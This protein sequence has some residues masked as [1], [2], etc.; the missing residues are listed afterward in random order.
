MNNMPEN[1]IP[2]VPQ[3]DDAV[4]GKEAG[5]QMLAA[6]CA[7]RDA[8]YATLGTV[9][10]D[11]LAWRKEQAVKAVWPMRESLLVCLRPGV[12]A[13]RLVRSAA[14][15]AGQLQVP[16]HA[17]YVE[18]PRLQRLPEAER[19]RILK[20]LHLAH[21]LGAQITNRAADDSADTIV[22]YA[23][24][25][26]LG[27]V[28]LG[29]EQPRAWWWQRL[30][31]GLAQRLLA[32]APDLDI[33]Q[34]A[35]AGVDGERPA[36]ERNTERTTALGANASNAADAANPHHSLQPVQAV[37]F[38]PGCLFETVRFVENMVLPVPNFGF[39]H[40]NMAH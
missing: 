7:A 2:H 12:G 21:T 32:R 31:P 3:P 13:E 15:L 24:E 4:V 11:V 28:L 35:S 23:R 20:A 38:P 9:D 30:R 34:L 10:A 22:A 1:D 16:W 17:L 6:A 5:A 14:R 27:K 19:A 37:F 8:F 33:M 36:P 39:T 40:S 29:R 18:T 25:H 26:N